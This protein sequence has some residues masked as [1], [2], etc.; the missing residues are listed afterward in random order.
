VSWK[1]PS[2]RRD[3][4]YLLLSMVP[5]G[6][7]ITYGTLA[8]LTGTSPR[9]IGVY[10]RTNS[11]PIVI[12][13]HR[14][15]ATKGLGGFSRGLEFKAKLLRI[16]DALDNTGRPKRLIRNVDEFW[17]VLEAQGLPLQAEID[18]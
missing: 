8:E 15:V 2:S 6:Y 10:M 16:E 9:A 14:V 18:P 11:E 7:T 12:P 17:D 3:L 5:I 13:C 4:V 1:D